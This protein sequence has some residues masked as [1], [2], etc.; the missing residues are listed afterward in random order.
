MAS[1]N[2]IINGK[3][4]TRYVKDIVTK[5]TRNDLVKKC[6]IKIKATDL[7]SLI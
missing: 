4:V 5:R 3:T 1:Y 7:E 2:V 6:E